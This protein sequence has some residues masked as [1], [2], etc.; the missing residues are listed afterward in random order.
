MNGRSTFRF[1]ALLLVGLLAL[2]GLGVLMM[3]I[4]RGAGGTA[5]PAPQSAFS[6]LPEPS[7]EPAVA[8]VN[9]R[10]IPHS[11]WVE[12]VLLDRVMS[13]FAG[14]PASTPEET[15][16]RLINEM[17]ILEAFPSVEA[18]SA[19]EVEAHIASL[20]QGWGVEDSAVVAALQEAGLSRPSLERA[21]GRLLKVQAGIEALRAQGYNESDWLKSKLAEA[22]VVINTELQRATVFPTP[23]SM[24]AASAPAPSPTAPLSPVSP[25]T[26]TGLTVAPDFVLERAD[27]GVFTLTQQLAAG[28]VVLV[29]F[30]RCG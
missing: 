20:E 23:P 29:F 6:P 14:Q 28:P 19:A 9:G 16:R 25:P 26:P 3:F 4:N 13:T 7:E 30:Q 1:L 8:T 10:P 2:G 5:T 18:P 27:G 11:L 12:S 15:L 21:I 22:K 17:L 24:A